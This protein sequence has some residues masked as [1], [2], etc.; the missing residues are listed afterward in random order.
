MSFFK[1]LVLFFVL[2]LALTLSACGF[3][4][5][6]SLEIVSP[7]RTER[8]YNNDAP[9]ETGLPLEVVVRLKTNRPDISSIPARFYI[10]D[11]AQSPCSLTVNDVTTCQ[12]KLVD[13]GIEELRVEVDTIDG[14]VIK[15]ERSFIWK[16][17]SGIEIPAQYLAKVF[18]SNN[19]TD[20]LL[21]FG[22]IIMAILGGMAIYHFK[23]HPILGGITFS[24]LI[25]LFFVLVYAKFIDQVQA[26]MMFN[27]LSG[28]LGGLASSVIIAYM[29][30]NLADK[31]YAVRFPNHLISHSTGYYPE[32]LGGGKM[33][34]SHQDLTQGF[35]AGP[36]EYLP[37]DVR[38]LVE[39]ANT[40]KA[41]PLFADKARFLVQ[42]FPSQKARVNVID[43]IFDDPEEREYMLKTTNAIARGHLLPDGSIPAVPIVTHTTSGGLLDSIVGF[44]KKLLK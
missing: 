15:A 8:I 43:G 3:K 26:T 30:T 12:I 40:L 29:I 20:G 9:S 34:E 11:D 22:G 6:T 18:S 37:D 2:P 32:V 27:S 5:E 25:F 13:T 10:N 41:L 33:I 7:G 38:I 42:E 1:K 31:H 17:I 35:Y 44:A 24:L 23:Q 39:V 19:P 36:G 21:V 14:T 4:E 16:P 28:I